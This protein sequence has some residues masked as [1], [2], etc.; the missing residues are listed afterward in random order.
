VC[1]KVKVVAFLVFIP[2]PH[3]T[4]HALG[5]VSNTLVKD[6]KSSFNHEAYIRDGE[7]TV[8]FKCMSKSQGIYEFGYSWSMI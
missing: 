7:K 6:D 3:N 8:V 5:E 2:V 1:I 4:L